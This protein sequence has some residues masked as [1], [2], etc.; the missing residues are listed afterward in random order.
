MCSGAG[1]ALTSLLNVV[2]VVERPHAD[3]IDRVA[4][5]Q[6]RVREVI[7]HS[8]WNGRVHSA[9]DDAI[10]FHRPERLGQHLLAD[11]VHLAQQHTEP[12]RSLRQDVD[13][14]QRPLVGDFNKDFARQR[15]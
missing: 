10:A 12:D 4:K 3:A 8:G 1:E 6:P 15:S 5:S 13:D 9:F 11:A 14:E 2:E 7:V